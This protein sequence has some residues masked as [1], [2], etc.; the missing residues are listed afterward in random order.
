MAKRWWI[1]F[2]L[3]LLLPIM[4]WAWW[5]SDADLRAVDA[6]TRAMGL[7]ATWED[8]HLEL[9]PAEDRTRLE[10]I[11]LAVE[12]Y[13]ESWRENFYGPAPG[14]PITDEI[15]QRLRD[16][17]PA[18]LAALDAVA[19]RPVTWITAM[20]LNSKLPH[21]TLNRSLI[22]LLLAQWHL[23]D[24]AGQARTWQRLEHVI[25]TN[26]PHTLIEE[27]VRCSVRSV[28]ASALPTMVPTHA[29][30][31]TAW[32]T[33]QLAESPQVL[34]SAFQG[35]YCSQRAYFAVP[36]AAS[37]QIPII[38]FPSTLF[39]VTV[40]DGL[41]TA[42]NRPVNAVLIR[43][44]RAAALRRYRDQYL[45]PLS[46]MTDWR[47]VVALAKQAP[48][49]FNGPASLVQ[50]YFMGALPLIL[51]QELRLRVQMAAVDA[52]C[53]QRPPPEDL[54]HPTPGKTLQPI[55]RA[56]RTIGWYSVGKNQVDDGG[57]TGSDWCFPLTERLGSPRAADPPVTP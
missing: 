37:N 47:D 1:I 50:N 13:G 3:G 10:A 45:Y 14:R 25:A 21:I 19:P 57:M 31:A 4:S 30:E 9:S 8:L 33:R 26:V 51:H 35:E 41:Q 15:R 46:T 39:D 34:T 29:A 23:E 11:G 22:R 38:T 40:P 28:V 24:P 6:E 16:R 32:L 49:S 20:S 54:M 43:W 27:L 53:R 12:S 42:I 36:I 2:G 17:P 18:F 55:I 52:Y 48:P 56:G 5:T 7:A 44:G